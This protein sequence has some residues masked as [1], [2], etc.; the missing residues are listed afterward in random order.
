MEMKV[1]KKHFRI[2]ERLFP[3]INENNKIYFSEMPEGKDPDDYIKENGKRR[4]VKFD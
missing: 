3:L 4:F 2:A 1:D